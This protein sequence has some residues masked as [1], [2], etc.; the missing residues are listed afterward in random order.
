M[1]VSVF[2]IVVFGKVALLHIS[3][4]SNKDQV[5]VLNTALWSNYSDY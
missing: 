1:N 3:L 5:F 4:K 2:I